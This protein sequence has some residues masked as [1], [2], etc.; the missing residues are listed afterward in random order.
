MSVA[1]RLSSLGSR[2][3]AH[4][5]GR[6]L[7]TGAG[8][9][10][11]VAILFGVLVANATTQVGVD[12]LFEDFTGRADVVASPIGVF[13][14]T[15]P[16]GAVDRL[17]S[18]P[19]VREVSGNYGTQALLPGAH[20]E[21]AP[22]EP[23]NIRVAGVVPE[24]DVKFQNYVFV[25]GGRFPTAPDEAILSQELAGDLHLDTGEVVGVRGPAQTLDLRIVGLL[26]RKGAGRAGDGAIAYTT[27]DTARALGGEGPGVFDGAGLILADGTEAGSWLDANQDAID[28]VRLEDASN[29]AAGFREF[30]EVFGTFLTFFAGITLFVGAFLIYLTLSMAVIERTRMYGTLRALGATKA[31]V[32]RVVLLEAI[33]LGA[34]S[35]VLGLLLGLGLAWVL[36]RLIGAL[37]EL[38]VSGLEIG[39]GSVIG[40]V[41]VGMLVTTLASLLPAARAGRLAPVEAMKGDH[42]RD[43]KLG[44]MWIFGAAVLVVCVAVQ[45]VTAQSE[46]GLGSLS[47]IGILLG[48]VLLTPLLLRPLA[49]LLGRAT[50]RLARGVGEVAVLHLAKERS[51]SAYTLALVM[52]VMAMLFAT[53]GLYLSVRGAMDEIVERQFGADMFISS[54]GSDFGPPGRLAS[55]DESALHARTDLKAISPVRFGNTSV[56]RATGDN[57]FVLVRVIEPDSY[58]DI[59]GYFWSDGDDAAAEQALTSG[60]GVLVSDGVARRLDLERGDEV[61]LLT[62]KG[63][64]AFEVAGLYVSPPGPPELSMGFKDGAAYLAAS[65]PIAYIADVTPGADPDAVGARI[66]S[67]LGGRVDVETTSELRAE[68]SGQIGSYFRIVYAILLV[69][70]IVGLLGLANTLAMSVLQR[71]REIGILRAIGVTRSQTWRM[72]LVESST[73][74]LVAFILS[75]PLGWLLTFLVVSTTSDGFGFEMSTV[76]P[77]TWIPL[78]AGFGILVAVVAA[79]APGRRAAR[80]EVVG[81]LQYE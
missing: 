44:R 37:F 59:A 48:T 28:G 27:I 24:E 72:V 1:R 73:M 16:E 54:G 5:K 70:A 42:V 18:L 14:A 3:L 81:A 36:L 4:R 55:E 62:R 10:L 74:G 61:T 64:V 68:V 46:S 8:I 2:S 15:L 30:L 47:V 49:S 40:A 7:L 65:D 39:P 45:P 41:I 58:F 17:R 33:A 31:Q 38:D 69:A 12:R 34:V 78:V 21:D 29:I 6:S 13:D 67:D 23:V 71:F 50:N 66:E 52:V 51:R 32:R 20:R 43:T 56:K 11:G 80:L 35:T 26:E 9:V 57:E 76:Y 22:D 25:P 19:D 53:G 75:V 77:W 63:R 79:L 60:G